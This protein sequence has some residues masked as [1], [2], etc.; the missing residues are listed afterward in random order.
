[1]LLVHL[2]DDDDDDG[3]CKYTS[4]SQISAASLEQAASD[5]GLYINSDNIYL[6]RKK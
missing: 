3:S 1:M 5:I 4:S 2:D 6:N